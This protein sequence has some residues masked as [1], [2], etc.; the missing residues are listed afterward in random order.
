VDQITESTRIL[1]RER[2]R[3]WRANQKAGR[4]GVC[5]TTDAVTLVEGLVAAGLLSYDRT[6]DRAA[7]NAATSRLVEL[8]LLSGKL[9]LRE[10]P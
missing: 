2:Q 10:R 7:I 1:A 5:F 8:M 9:P 6:E 3:R 4:I